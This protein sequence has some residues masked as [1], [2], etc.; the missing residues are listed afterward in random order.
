[1]GVYVVNAGTQNPEVCIE[2]LE[3]LCMNNQSHYTAYFYQDSV[4]LLDPQYDSRVENLQGLIQDTQ[5][6]LADGNLDAAYRAE[7]EFRLERQQANLQKLLDNEDEK[8]LVSAADLEHF[9]SYADCVFVQMPGL[10]NANDVE[11]AQAFKQLKKR[12]C[13]GQ[14]SATEL[15]GTRSYKNICLYPPVN[16]DGVIKVFH[17]KAYCLHNESLQPV[18]LH[19]YLHPFFRLQISQ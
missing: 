11:N 17:R 12:F 10:F 4:P 18:S 7:L 6:Q 1:M 2:L 3:S 8:Y 14:M 16:N 15:V 19:A 9:R 5:R 13:T